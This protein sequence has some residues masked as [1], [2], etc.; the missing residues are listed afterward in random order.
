MKIGKKKLKDNKFKPPL[1]VLIKGEKY[2]LYQ[3]TTDVEFWEVV[4]TGAIRD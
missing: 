2:K 4:R 1:T 3:Q